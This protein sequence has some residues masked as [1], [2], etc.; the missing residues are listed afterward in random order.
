MPQGSV[1]SPM[2][3]NFFTYDIPKLDYCKL[4]LFADDTAIFTSSKFFKDISKK[5]NRDTIK[6][7]RFFSKWK[8]KLNNSKSVACYFTRRRTKQ[9]PKRTDNI[10]VGDNH[11][12]W[13]NVIKYLGCHLEGR[14]TMKTQI[15]SSINK[16]IMSLKS[17]YPLVNRKSLLSVSVKNQ[18]YK[19]YFRPVLV[20]PAT[21]TKRCA[22]TTQQKIQIS[23]N[24]LLRLFNNKPWDYKTSNLHEET[25]METIEEFLG[26]LDRRLVEKSADHDNSLIQE[27]FA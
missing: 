11:I 21:L 4:A 19:L 17:L 27:L 14:L 26:K 8:I 18:I 7:I 25:N 20:Y 5:L 12:P 9:I 23:Q 6:L 1:L 10:K 16:S 3:Y 15:K 24:K 2:L 22:R 13:N